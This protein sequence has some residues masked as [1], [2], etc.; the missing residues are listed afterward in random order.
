MEENYA[1]AKIDGKSTDKLE[2]LKEM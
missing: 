1:S 2:S